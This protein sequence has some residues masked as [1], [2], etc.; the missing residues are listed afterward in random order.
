MWSSMALKIQ[1]K[2]LMDEKLYFF[3]ERFDLINS[4][5]YESIDQEYLNNKKACGNSL[6][7]CWK[8]LE[9]YFE[10]NIYTLRKPYR[11]WSF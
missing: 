1:T 9:K 7:Q 11:T 6:K 10:T 8:Q 2:W 3:V 5:Y 4:I